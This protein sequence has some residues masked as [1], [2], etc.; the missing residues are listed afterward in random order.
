MSEMFDVISVGSATLDVLMKSSKFMIR[1]DNLCELYGSKTE[2]EMARVTVGGSGTNTAVSFARKELKTACIAEIGR[3]MAG[4][5]VKLDLEKE[6]VVTEFLAEEEDEETA[7]AAILVAGN[8]ERS[9]IVRRGA[10]AMLEKND[11]PW[12]IKTRWMHIG[13][14]GGNLK[15]LKNLIKWAKNEGVRVSLN[16]G[17]L[18]LK[19]RDRVLE[20][21]GEVE[22]LFVNREEANKLFEGD[23]VKLSRV[24]VVTEGKR[25]G[26]LWLPDGKQV[27]FVG[28]EVQMVDATGAGDAFASGFVS[29]ILYGLDYKQA[30][31]WGKKN[32]AEVVRYMG[33]KKGLLTLAEIK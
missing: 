1:G 20:L 12:E 24:M 17:S 29:A 25:G 16:P 7:V 22:I 8:G 31:E 11:F 18:E 33:A 6:K 3:D 21:L 32:A 14:L 15:L 23:E 19:K 9:A 27:E 28:R 13:S 4:K 26:R 30:V 10:S 2:V 5:M